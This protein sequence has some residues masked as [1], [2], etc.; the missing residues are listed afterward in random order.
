M[1]RQARTWSGVV[2]GFTGIPKT[3]WRRSGICIIKKHCK[4]TEGVNWKA[5]A[6]LKGL[7][8]SQ[9]GGTM[10]GRSAE[11]TEDWIATVQCGIISDK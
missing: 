7:E 3:A 4:I 5:G 9:R 6:L 11:D 10:S 2:N 1:D 8:W